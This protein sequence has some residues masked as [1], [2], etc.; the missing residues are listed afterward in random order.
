MHHFLITYC[1]SKMIYFAEIT[2]ICDV[3]RCNKAHRYLLCHEGLILT[4][5]QAIDSQG[6]ELCPC[7]MS[8]L[9]SYLL[10]C[11]DQF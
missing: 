1:S 2:V 7:Q 6:G 3:A 8:I 11:Q 5:T 9:I 4:T 10:A